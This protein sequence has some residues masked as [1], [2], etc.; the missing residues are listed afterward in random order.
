[1]ERSLLALK[2]VMVMKR[3]IMFLILFIYCFVIMFTGCTEA[4]K[5]QQRC[6]K[7]GNPATTS[8]MGPADIIRKNGISV[9]SCKEITSG[10]YS[11][12]VCDSC[13]GHV[14]EIKPY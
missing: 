8:L 14:A 5:T 1:M 3:N 10:V 6:V 2:A 13:V 11:A 7:C 4:T 9:S 12:S